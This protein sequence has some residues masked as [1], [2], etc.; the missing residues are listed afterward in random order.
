LYITIELHVLWILEQ[1]DST[2]MSLLEVEHITKSAD[3][4]PIL[5]GITLRIE[6]GETVALIG[7]KGAG[8]TT[9]LK[10][11]VRLL[12]PDSGRIAILGT[13]WDKTRIRAKIGYLPEDITG[14]YPLSPRTYLFFHSKLLGMSR[15]TA[16]D[17]ITYLLHI[18]GIKNVANVKMSRLS[19]CQL[20]KVLFVSSILG[21]P[22][23]LLLDEPSFRL[24]T[25]GIELIRDLIAKTRDEGKGILIASS[26]LSEIEKHCD[27]IGIIRNGTLVRMAAL[28]ELSGLQNSM[29]LRVEGE[30][31]AFIRQLAD[32]G[33]VCTVDGDEIIL[34]DFEPCTMETIPGLLERSDCRLVSM[35]FERRGFGEIIDGSSKRGE[36]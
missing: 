19:F 32:S 11:I 8:K 9:F 33:T 14:E 34:H 18:A 24:D 28:P 16:S 35:H 7:P 21:S 12:H 36:G 10:I 29:V 20:K 15:G 30:R 3:S 6:R 31:N 17:R 25:E 2:E 5:N 22:E 27:R 26:G 23:L 13:G 4:S 1:L